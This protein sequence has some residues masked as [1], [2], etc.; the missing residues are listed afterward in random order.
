MSQSIEPD[1]GHLNKDQWNSR[2]KLVFEILKSEL[3]NKVKL[4]A[5]TF[6][7]IAVRVL[8][9]F[10]KFQQVQHVRLQL[11]VFWKFFN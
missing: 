5:E 11:L 9:L 3:S 8:S 1:E 6:L 4:V 2:T 7:L 10:K